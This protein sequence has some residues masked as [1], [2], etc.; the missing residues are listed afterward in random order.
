MESGGKECARTRVCGCVCPC[1]CVC[2]YLH[3]RVCV[4]TRVGAVVCEEVG[5][6]WHGL[7]GEVPHGMEH[8]SGMDPVVVC[9]GRE[10]R[11]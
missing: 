3:M 6:A 1:M 2:L 9:M 7:G 5:Q 4:L 10:R 11:C 8:I